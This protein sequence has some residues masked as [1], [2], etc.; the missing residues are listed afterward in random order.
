[1]ERKGFLKALGLGV[2]SI[3]VTTSSIIAKD[4]I[5]EIPM[6]KWE[7]NWKKVKTKEHIEK[8]AAANRGKKRSLESRTKM[9]LAK[10]GRVNGPLS[11]KT[12]T[13][14]IKTKVDKGIIKKVFQYDRENNL[15]QIHNGINEAA[16]SVN[17]TAANIY[18]CLKGKTYHAVNFIWKYN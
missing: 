18:S 8:I 6:G 1:M 7:L 15:I 2:T 16:R 12:K 9:S 11:L 5:V 3:S 10:K 13:T 14:I 4:N 17:T